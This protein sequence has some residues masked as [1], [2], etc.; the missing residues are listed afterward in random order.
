[1]ATRC[2]PLLDSDWP[3]ITR[4]K[5]RTNRWTLVVTELRTRMMM[6]SKTR[7]LHL[8]LLTA[9]HV[10]FAAT[11]FAQTA[12]PDKDIVRKTGEYMNALAKL[13][14]FRGS[15]LVARGGKGLERGNYGL[16]RSGLNASEIRSVQLGL[17]GAFKQVL[18]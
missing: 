12:P 13:N 4:L 7:F 1:M 15:I 3:A 14:R 8:A 2:K 6:N 9:T 16:A 18:S 17:P 11:C 5:R 10:L